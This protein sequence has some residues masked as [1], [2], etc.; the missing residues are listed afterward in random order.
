VLTIPA[1]RVPI[2]PA[3]SALGSRLFHDTRLSST[4]ARSCDSCHQLARAYADALPTPTSLEPGAPITRNTPTLLYASLQAAFLWDGR[5]TT[6]ST[7]AL[8]VIHSSS[9][10]G[11]TSAALEARVAADP[12][13]RA[14]FAAAF[15]D[16]VTADN[17]AQALASFEDAAF[18]RTTAPVDRLARGALDALDA[19]EKA[20]F[21]AFV[22]PGRC[23]RC[24]VPPTFGGVRPADFAVTIYGALGVPTDPRGTALDPDR[25]RAAITR[26]AK[27]EGAFKTPT[28]RNIA[29]TGPYFHN[30]AFPTLEGVVDFYVRGGGRGLG[31]TVPN[32]DVE[33]RPLD[34]TPS[35]REGLL[36]F[37][38]VALDDASGLR[39]R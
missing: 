23:S 14:A 20:G 22:A 26:A 31:L 15:P 10:L 16:G 35:E 18:V 17:V 29:R 5:V 6:A 4:G 30:G 37:L 36:R 11:L 33:V 24:H 28:L 2:D 38:R 27:D 8:R 12:S 13:Y 39:A 7:Q 1:P 25:G 19:R 3:R 21:D 34:L 9:E 32:Q